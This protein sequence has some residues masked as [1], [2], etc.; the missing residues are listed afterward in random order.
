MAIRTTGNNTTKTIIKRQVQNGKIML[1][2]SNG[3]TV[4]ASLSDWNRNSFDAK[5]LMVVGI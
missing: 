5:I 3:I 4:L 2:F 1:T